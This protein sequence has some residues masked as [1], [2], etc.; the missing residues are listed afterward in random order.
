MALNKT[1]NAALFNKKDTLLQ[2]KQLLKQKDV[3][4]QQKFNPHHSVAKLLKEKS[5]FIDKVLSCCWQHFLGDY[6]SKLAL[7][8]TK[9]RSFVNSTISRATS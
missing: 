8:A 2:F 6:A 5:A 4:L 1:I 7:C 9:I 3:E